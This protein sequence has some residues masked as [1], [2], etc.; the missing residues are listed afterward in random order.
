V[1]DL[2][3]LLAE[4]HDVTTHTGIKAAETSGDEYIDEV[5]GPGG[6]LAQAK[7]GYIM[8]D[9]QVQLARAVDA[10][11]RERRTLLAEA[12]TGTGKSFAYSVSASYH[13][14]HYHRRVVIVTANI[15]LQEQLVESDLPFL[16]EHLPWKFNFAIAKGWSNYLCL[17]AATDA[18]NDHLRGRRL[19]VLQATSASCPSS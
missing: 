15:A 18:R 12:P 14:A 16:Q 17:D 7:P 2:P 4:G 6:V 8:R 9:S 19:P 11:F 5:F 3:A 13:A 1:G 10:T